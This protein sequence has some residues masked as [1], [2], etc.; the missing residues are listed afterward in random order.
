M[1]VCAWA[2]GG[3]H[4]GGLTP[5]RSWG[6]LCVFVRISVYLCAFAYICMYLLSTCTYL[7]VAARVCEYSCVFVNILR[8]FLSVIV[9]VFVC[10]NGGWLT[11]RRPNPPS[12]MNV[13]SIRLTGMSDWY[14]M[15]KDERSLAGTRA[16]ARPI[17]VRGMWCLRMK[18]PGPGVTQQQWR[19]YEIFYGVCASSWAWG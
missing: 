14:V 2:G 3:W 10:M 12:L 4:E 18:D 6:W 9:C 13:C 5:L 7:H 8:I 11:W 16:R 1:C 19:T 15:F 17:E